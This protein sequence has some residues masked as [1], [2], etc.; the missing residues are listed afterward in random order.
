MSDD[1]RRGDAGSGDSGNGITGY[2]VARRVTGSTDI[3][4]R[5]MRKGNHA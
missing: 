5:A 4:R 1:T 3:R 2:G